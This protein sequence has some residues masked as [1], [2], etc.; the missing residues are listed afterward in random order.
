MVSQESVR[1]AEVVLTFSKASREMSQ[2]TTED[3]WMLVNQQAGQQQ[4]QQSNAAHQDIEIQGVLIKA[5]AS[6]TLFED[7]LSYA[8][9]VFKRYETE[10]VQAF[11]GS[12]Q[13]KYRIPLGN[14]LEEHGEWTWQAA[15]EEGYR[16]IDAEKKTKRRSARLMAGSSQP[17]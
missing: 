12:V 9:K 14:K 4:R 2:A 6:C 10:A 1:C 5:Q 7:H 13:E 11:V 3:E 17:S 16:I 8:E 15:R